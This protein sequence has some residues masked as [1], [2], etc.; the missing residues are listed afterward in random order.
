MTTEQ[1]HWTAPGGEEIVVPHMGK[2]KTGL[3]RQVRALEGVDGTFTIL[4][5]IA[6]EDTLRKI[7]D[8]D[9]DQFDQ[10]SKAWQ[11]ASTSLGESGVSST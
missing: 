3:L 11:E 5:K 7:D 8:L 1:F 4:E 6:D 9:I 10:F 2:L